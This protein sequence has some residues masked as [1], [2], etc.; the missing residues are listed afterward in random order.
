MTTNTSPSTISFS[1]KSHDFT[2]TERFTEG[3]I[4]SPGEAQALNRYITSSLKAEIL[5]GNI[6]TRV[7]AFA[8]I[9]GDKS[10]APRVLST[11]TQRGP[12]V[13]PYL[14]EDL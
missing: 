2:F 5:A 10:L 13:D 9:M 6:T 4:P 7:E 8:F 1:V 11:N 14:L 12:T 3:A